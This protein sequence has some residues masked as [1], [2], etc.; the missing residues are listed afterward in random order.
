MLSVVGGEDIG[1][2]NAIVVIRV[3]NNSDYL[4]RGLDARRY[5]TGSFKLRKYRVME[6]KQIVRMKSTRSNLQYRS[7]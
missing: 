5:A 4:D 7:M 3:G 1:Q 6:H 2:V